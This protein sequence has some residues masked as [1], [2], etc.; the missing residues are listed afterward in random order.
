MSRKAG[1]FVKGNSDAAETA[2]KAGHGFSEE[3]LHFLAR[4][5]LP[6]VRASRPVSGEHV[7]ADAGVVGGAEVGTMGR[8]AVAAAARLLR[9]VMGTLGLRP[10]RAPPAV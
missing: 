6:W 5:P 8:C 2:I 4:C 1:V 9:Q 10:P 7:G 3:R